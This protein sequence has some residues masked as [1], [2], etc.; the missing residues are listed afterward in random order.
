MDQLAVHIEAN[1]L[2]LRDAINTSAAN[3][4]S[5]MA[6]AVICEDEAISH[7]DRRFE[8]FDGITA[9]ESA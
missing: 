3:Q 7:K 6:V 5:P 8:I 2:L 1:R 4:P 9:D